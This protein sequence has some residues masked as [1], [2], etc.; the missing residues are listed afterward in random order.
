MN[1]HILYG[2]MALALGCSTVACNDDDID[3]YTSPIV[4]EVLTGEASTTATTATVSGVA[5]DLSSQSSDAYTV[6]VVYSTTPDPTA[7]GTM[8]AGTMGDDGKFVTTITGLQEGRTYYYAA[9]VSL[10]NRLTYYGDI[11]SF[12]TTSGQ[13]GTAEAASL[14]STGATLGGTLNG[15]SDLIEAGTLDYGVV[16]AATP[17]EIAASP[18]RIAAEGTTNSFTVKAANLVPNTTYH[19]AA[20][21][22]VGG[23]EIFGNTMQFTTPM[24]CDASQE[25]ADDYVDMGT[26]VEW[27]RYN[28]G[29]AAEGEAG[30]LLGFGD[31]RGLNRSVSV[32]DYAAGNIIGTDADVATAAGMGQLPSADNFRELLAVSDISNE[33]VNG[34]PCVKFTSKTTGNAIYF[35]MAGFRENGE[36]LSAGSLGLYATGESYSDQPDYAYSLRLAEGAAGSVELASRATAMSVRPVRKPYSNV[37]TID[38]SKILYGDI[39]NNGRLRIEIFNAF[40]STS[41]NPP[42]DMSR[43][44]F[45]KSMFVTFRLEGIDGNLV[46][47]ASGSYKA[48]LQFAA[49]GWWP[50]RWTGYTNEKYDCIVT[51]DG[52]YT[53]WMETTG[54]AN[55]AEVFCVDVNGLSADIA[56]MS[57]VKAE[58]VGIALDPAKAPVQAVEVDNAK[59]L[60]V[61][62]DGDGVNGR[63]EI[64]NEY[65]ET[66]GL[67][68]DFSSMRFPAGTMTVTFT[69]EGLAEALNPGATNN[70]T[71][72]LSYAAASWDPSYWGGQVGTT[73]VTGD[74]TYSV[75]AHLGG[76]CEGAVVWCVEVYGLWGELADPSKVKVTVNNVTVPAYTE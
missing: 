40:G 9:C 30:A 57:K 12:V 1:K 4:S 3:V 74:G 68:A 6:G 27:C 18:V 62:K 21:M 39:E 15:V 31:T 47:G 49:G 22:V 19:Y 24:L 17:G 70:W 65:G 53:V 55:G 59:V 13:A 11:K 42:M 7:G 54:S 75:Q 14:T 58:V 36:E 73:Q 67:G 45:D 66:K 64:F 46:E 61:N 29:A 51:G 44:S 60:F 8:Q 48:G 38:N 72:D 35:P 56:D 50:D 20:Y 23:E 76:D 5:R 71:A 43:L 26:K 37:L 63:I 41:A 34:V 2:V 69:I 33:T 16:L 25:S 52:T 32:S 10:Q 28:V